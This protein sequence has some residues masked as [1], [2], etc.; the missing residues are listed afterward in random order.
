MNCATCIHRDS[1]GFCTN[2]KLH[3]Q[4]HVSDKLPHDS[5]TND[6][7]I[8]SYQEGGSFWVG[9]KFGCVHYSK[10]SHL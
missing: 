1:H 2:P 9:P 5:E 8:Y 6:E 3:E 4:S 7:L 10:K